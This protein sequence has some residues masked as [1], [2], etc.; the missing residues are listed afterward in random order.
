MRLYFSNLMT[1]CMELRYGTLIMRLNHITNYIICV[2]RHACSISA[3]LMPMQRLILRH[4]P[5]WFITISVT[6]NL[7][8]GKD[9]PLNVIGT[10]INCHIIS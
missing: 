10:R 9:L 6:C 3:I 1:D 5:G 7:L 8:T 2:H 4:V